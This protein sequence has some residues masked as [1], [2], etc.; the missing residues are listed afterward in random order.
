MPIVSVPCGPTIFLWIFIFGKIR[1][2]QILLIVMDLRKSSNPN[3]TLAMMLNNKFIL[4]LS[5]E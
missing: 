4:F 3:T 2:M 1:P 5:V